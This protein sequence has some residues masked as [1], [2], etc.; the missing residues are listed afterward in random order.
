MLKRRACGPCVGT[1]PFTP[2]ASA[3]MR[4]QAPKD[5]LEGWFYMIM[6]IIVG[7]FYGRL[8]CRKNPGQQLNL[9]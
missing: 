5:D 6:E 1:F 7:M 2:L 9:S 4:D 3:T 8:C